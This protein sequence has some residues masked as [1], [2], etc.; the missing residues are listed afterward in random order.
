M[1]QAISAT[2]N[3]FEFSQLAQAA[4]K[5]LDTLPPGIPSLSRDALLVERLRNGDA[6]AFEEMVREFGG[7]LLATARRYL[8][9]EA[10]ACDALQ[11]ALLCAFKSIHTFKGGSQLS[12]WLHRILVNSAL[13]HLRSKKRHP[14]VPID[15]TF[16][17]FDNVAGWPDEPG[18]GM[19]TEA[20]LE[21]SQTKVQVR[22]CIDQM[23][24]IYRNV[25]IMRN[26][27][28]L[29]TEEVAARL[30]LTP[31]NVKVRLHRAR[32]AFKALIESEQVL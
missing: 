5:R 11:D 4:V 21:I 18:Y 23:P 2:T 10:D 6:L 13:M 3:D 31:T 12:T 9:S 14:E 26:I 30:G 24:E 17:Q 25:L 29:D 7:R 8:R 32:Q 28:E 1:L 15:D 27:E 20:A 19:Q 22:R 16:P